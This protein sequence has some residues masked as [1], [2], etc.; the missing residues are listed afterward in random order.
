MQIPV[1]FLKGTLVFMEDLMSQKT[2][3]E[4]QH[5]SSVDYQPEFSPAKKKIQN[6]PM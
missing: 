2:A 6:F 1:L 3:N 4:L 5:F